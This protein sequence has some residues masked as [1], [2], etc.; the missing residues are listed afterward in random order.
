LWVAP[1][2]SDRNHRQYAEEKKVVME[3]LG[4]LPDVTFVKWQ[5]PPWWTN[6]LPFFWS[7]YE[8]HVRYTYQLK[9]QKERSALLERLEGSVRTNLR[10]AEEFLEVRPASGL[11]DLWKLKQKSYRQKPGRV[12]FSRARLERLHEAIQ[13]QQ[14]GQLYSVADAAGRVYAAAY[15]LWDDQW[16]Y[17]WLSALDPDVKSS[18][19]ATLLLWELIGEAGKKGLG[20]DFE[21]SM[22]AGIEQ[23]F[24]AFEAERVPYLEVF[25]A[26]SRLTKMMY[27]LWS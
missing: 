9:E 8:L 15:L 16:A 17:Y 2:V 5:L 22:D 19:A 1:S 13:A 26:K 10:K 6:G 21:G 11:N 7:G 20:F 3:L 23:L 18:G 4:Q 27:H 24:R 14:S 12:P 25:K